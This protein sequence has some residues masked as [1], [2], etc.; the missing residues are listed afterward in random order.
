MVCLEPKTNSTNSNRLAMPCVCC[1]V[2]SSRHGDLKAANVLLTA[3]SIG[4]ATDEVW[5]DASCLPLTAKV[6]DFGLAMSLG[7]T[8]THA[9]MLARV[10]WAL[11]LLLVTFVFEQEL[12]I[13]VASS[14]SKAGCAG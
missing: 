7:P 10:S 12:Y 11:T 9:T 8:D 13:G 14:F 3:G 4:E 6:A 2:H 1:A 5:A